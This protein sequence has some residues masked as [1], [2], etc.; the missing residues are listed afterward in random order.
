MQTPSLVFPG[1]GVGLLQFLCPGAEFGAGTA[2]QE[3]WAEQEVQCPCVP[4]QVLGELPL[5]SAYVLV[6][7]IPIYWL[8][9]LRPVPQ[10]FFL[11]LLFIWLVVMSCRA[12]GLTVAALLP[13]LHMSS[14]C[15]N[16]LYS[17][18]YFTGGFMVQLGNLWTGGPDRVPFGHLGLAERARPS[19]TS[20]LRSARV[21]LEGFLP[22]L[23]LPRPD[24]DPPQ[25]PD[26]PSTRGG[27]HS[28]HPGELGESQCSSQGRWWVP[29]HP[30]P[31]PEPGRQPL[32][33][34]PQVLSSM[35]LD[36][37]PL[38]TAVLVLLA[39]SACFLGFYYLALR[40]IRQTPSQDW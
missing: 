29:T 32:F 7:G 30:S 6:Y 13:T 8:A 19:G 24:A 4:L 17:I 22:A 1:A 38:S 35:G 18:F 15:G 2:K 28:A 39:I 36:S 40:C 11:H 34:T 31:L 3:E 37:H 25:E 9:K 14:F 27:W 20:C 16:A 33:A 10:P 21:D 23:E 26:L 5:Y 12:M